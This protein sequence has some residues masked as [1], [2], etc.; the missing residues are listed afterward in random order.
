MDKLTNQKPQSRQML[1]ECLNKEAVIDL[2]GFFEVLIDIDQ[3][4]KSNN[5]CDEFSN[6]RSSNYS[7]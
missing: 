6:N 5:Q 7:N 3:T 4:L 1:K 2:A